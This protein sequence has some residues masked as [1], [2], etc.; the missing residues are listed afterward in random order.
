MDTH[1]F[2]LPLEQLHFDDRMILLE[3]GKKEKLGRDPS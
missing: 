1:P 2:Y 3:R